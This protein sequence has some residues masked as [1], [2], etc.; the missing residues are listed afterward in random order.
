M[1]GHK[2]QSHGDLLAKCRLQRVESPGLWQKR[3]WKLRAQVW[4]VVV[5]SLPEVYLEE[6][7]EQTEPQHQDT[8]RSSREERQ[9]PPARTWKVDLAQRWEDP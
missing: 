9:R 1:V 3:T 6:I 4:G 2:L 5:G 7:Q 8:G